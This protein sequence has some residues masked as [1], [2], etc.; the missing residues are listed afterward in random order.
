VARDNTVRLG[1]R[2]VQLRGGRSYAGITVEVR[3]L[4]DG[5]VVVLHDEAIVG[6]APSPGSTFI[7]KPRRAPGEDRRPP[8]AAAP[9]ARPQ[10]LQRLAPKTHTGR[11]PLPTHPWVRANN[12]DIRLRELRTGRIFSRSSGGGPNH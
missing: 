5:R 11:R 1:P 6:E 12:D 3:E 9:R 2:L 10:R 7:L 4:L 8:R